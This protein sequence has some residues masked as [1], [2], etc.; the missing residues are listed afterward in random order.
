MVSETLDIRVNAKPAKPG[1]IKKANLTLPSIIGVFLLGT[2]ICLA[3][4]NTWFGGDVTKL[5]FEVGE[6]KRIEPY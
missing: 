1:Q 3:L 6:L 4:A 5:A 2:F